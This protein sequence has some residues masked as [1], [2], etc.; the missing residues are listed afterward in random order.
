MVR[1]VKKGADSYSVV[2]PLSGDTTELINL[3]YEE[4]RG[5]VYDEMLGRKA[6]LNNST[7]QITRAT[8]VEAAEGLKEN[9]EFPAYN[10]QRHR[11]FSPQNKAQIK[12]FAEATE[13]GDFSSVNKATIDGKEYYVWFTTEL[14]KGIVADTSEAL[15]ASAIMVGAEIPAGEEVNA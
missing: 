6:S 15:T 11:H 10:I 5:N 7:R 1:L 14:T 13:S 9:Q 3:V 12:A 2:S 8:L 4:D